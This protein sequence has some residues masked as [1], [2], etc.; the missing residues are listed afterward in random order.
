MRKVNAWLVTRYE[1]WGDVIVECPIIAFQR[2]EMAERCMGTRDKRAEGAED[3][4]WHEIDEI[5]VVLDD[6][7]D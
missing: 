6:A 1:G 4:T 2:R 7:W 3:P 5:E